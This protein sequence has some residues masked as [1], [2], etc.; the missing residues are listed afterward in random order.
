M[1]GED[2]FMRGQSLIGTIFIA[3]IVMVLLSFAISF[4]PYILIGALIWY[5]VKS[6]VRPFLGQSGQ[7][8]Q[9][10]QWERKESSSY[11]PEAEPEDPIVDNQVKS[12][13]DDEFFK[14]QHHV[15]DV[16]YEEEDKK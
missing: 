14:Q 3:V 15:V 1:N 12:V 4:L 8:E 6:I 2:E 16:D 11:S 5:L 9:R 13:Y 7:S 10:E